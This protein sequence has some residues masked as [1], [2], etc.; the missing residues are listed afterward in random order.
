MYFGHLLFVSRD[1]ERAA[2]FILHVVR[3]LRNQLVPE[4]ARV[5]CQVKLG[6][7]IVH[8]DYMSHTCCGGPTARN[9]ALYQAD[10]QPRLG[11]LERASATYNTGTDDK[12]VKALHQNAM[13]PTK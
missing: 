7:R 10:P 2:C 12:N 4:R 1:P 5:A 9:I 8:D 3:Q 13:P 11:T 6:T